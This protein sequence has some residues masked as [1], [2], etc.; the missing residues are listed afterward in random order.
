[1]GEHPLHVVLCKVIGSTR[2][3]SALHA[4][5]LI[6]RSRSSPQKAACSLFVRSTF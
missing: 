1:M 3:L 5:I 6:S 4:S 2:S